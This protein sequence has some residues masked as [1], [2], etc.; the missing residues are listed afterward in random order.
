[1]LSEPSLCAVPRLPR[2]RPCCHGHGVPAATPSQLRFA[3]GAQAGCGPTEPPGLKCTQAEV[4][5]SFIT[6]TVREAQ[7]S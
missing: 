6:T 5:R 3:P 1:M 7:L 4:R 2:P